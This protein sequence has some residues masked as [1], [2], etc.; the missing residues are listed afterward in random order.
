MSHLQRH[1]F[2][3]LSPKVILSLLCLQCK[4]VKL[5]GATDAILQVSVCL[6]PAAVLINPYN[7]FLGVNIQYIS[8]NAPKTVVL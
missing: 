2:A 4:V 7:K 3:L 8:P 5:T 1:C 6:N